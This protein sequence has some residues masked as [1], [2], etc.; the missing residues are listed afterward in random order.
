MLIIKPS[1]E[2]CNIDLPV[3]S[4]LARI[5]SFECTFCKNCVEN[6]LDNCCP[7]C[8]G[9]FQVRPIRPVVDH[10]GGNYT[11][12]HPVSTQRL[13]RPVNF[14]EHSKLLLAVRHHLK[15]E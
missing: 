8:G 9:D 15:N 14:I 6:L 12:N 11:G 3:D 5:C 7:N 4:K 13:H 2:H 1:C 10:K